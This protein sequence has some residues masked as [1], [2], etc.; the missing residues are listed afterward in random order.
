MFLT[1]KKEKLNPL[2]N[3]KQ[4]RSVSRY[5]AIVVFL[6]VWFNC[7]LYFFAKTNQQIK[8]PKKVFKALI[9]KENIV[10][11]TTLIY[12]VFIKNRRFLHFLYFDAMKKRVETLDAARLRLCLMQQAK[13][14]K[15]LT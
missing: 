11:T 1:L 2:K 10:I 7:Y 9:V 3:Q 14:Q 8:K 4:A 12:V 15:F 6:I 5:F 13:M